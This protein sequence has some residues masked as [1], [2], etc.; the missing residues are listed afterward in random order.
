[1]TNLTLYRVLSFLVGVSGF[2]LALAIAGGVIWFLRAPLRKVL[3][4]LIGDKEIAEAGTWFVLVLL[5]VHGAKAALG[6]VTQTH[7]KLL[8]SGLIDLLM[9]MADVI[10]WVVYIA[11]LLFI[12][13]SLQARRLGAKEKEED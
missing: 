11:A 9:G 2:V 1:M 5:G 6:Y 3:Q 7:L 8:L 10:R 13:Y 4:Q 12:G